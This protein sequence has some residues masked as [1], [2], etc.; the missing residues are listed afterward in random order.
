MHGPQ[1]L[2]W[3]WAA[4]SHRW[5]QF[6]PTARR[7]KRCNNISH[8]NNIISLPVSSNEGAWS[9]KLILTWNWAAG[10][11]RWAQFSPNARRIRYNNNFHN[12]IIYILPVS[13]E[14][15]WSITHSSYTVMAWS[16]VVQMQLE[17]GEYC[18]TECNECC[19]C[20]L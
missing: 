10:S 20:T 8:D 3:N 14:G 5:A 2:T 7:I 11:H 12:N 4:G 1:I 15:A 17:N 16:L 18:M 9:T 19:I 13:N 6:S